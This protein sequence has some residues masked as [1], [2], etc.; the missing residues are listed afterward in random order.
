MELVPKEG[1]RCLASFYCS[2]LFNHICINHFC[3][4]IITKH[5]HITIIIF[6]GPWTLDPEA[7]G[8]CDRVRNLRPG[9]CELGRKKKPSVSRAF[10]IKVLEKTK[11]IN[12]DARTITLATLEVNIMAQDLPG[13]NKQHNPD[14]EQNQDPGQGI[15]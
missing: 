11:S 5:I 2:L 1:M 6:T 14:R 8:I 12:I 15:F 3:I 10:L 9:T 7:P 4:H 13:K